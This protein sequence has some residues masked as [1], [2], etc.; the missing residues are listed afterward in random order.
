[1]G[2]AM[3]RGFHI[4][5]ACQ[6]AVLLAVA[7]LCVAVRALTVCPQCAHEQADSANFCTHCGAALRT[8]VGTGVQAAASAATAPPAVGG[9]DPGNAPAASD[10]DALVAQV[11][12]E[13]VKL[14]RE[15]V[16]AGR[17]EVARAVFGNALAVSAVSPT[18]MTPAQGEQLMGEVRRCEQLLTQASVACAACE[19]T[20]KRALRLDSL[21]GDA[22][23]VAATGQNC[24]TCRGTGQTQR[25]RS[26]DDLKFVLG[27]ARQ[28]ADLAL[29]S[30]SRVPVGGAWI[31]AALRTLL[32]DETETR[33]RHAAAAPCDACQ[34]IGRTDCAAC[35]NTGF[36]A[37]KAKGCAQGWVVKD[38]LNKLDNV[39]ALK[40]RERCAQCGGSARV[41]CAAC[42][43]V[44]AVTCKTCSGSGKRAVCTACGGNGTGT[45]RACR[46]EGKKRDGTPCG[47]CGGDGVALCP[48]CRGDGYRSR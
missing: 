39:T 44:G 1:M 23:S 9:G 25:T 40:R 15:L 36:V 24:I 38:A 46:G 4:M 2:F 26:A 33:L 34:G 5:R 13:D 32:T 22:G 21:T 7:G 43:G 6:R 27:Q 48:T 14:G 42:H 20:G 8:G 47:E 28:Q 12:V 17:P 35:G 11:L 29:R 16:A 10:A 45:C 3:R 31:P 37:C 30:R 19:G 41:A 18:A